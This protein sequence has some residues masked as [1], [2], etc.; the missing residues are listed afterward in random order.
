MKAITTAQ[1]LNTVRAILTKRSDL[2]T[3]SACQKL[4]ANYIDC[5][6]CGSTTFSHASSDITNAVSIIS[7]PDACRITKQLNPN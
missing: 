2:M 3:C 6:I 4:N 1:A 5:C 7:I